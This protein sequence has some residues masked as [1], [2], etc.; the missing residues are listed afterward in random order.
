M[1]ATEWM[2]NMTAAQLVPFDESAPAW[3]Q[4]FYAFLAEKERRSGSKRTVD[5][6]SCTLQ[7]FFGA[8]GKT[9]DQVGPPDVFAFTHGVGPSGR[10]PAAITIGA[11]LA[12]VSSFYRFLMRMGIVTV[13]P[14][15][16]LE[17]PRVSPAPPRGL[18]AE[19]IKRL[20]CVIPETP[21]GLRDRAIIITLALTGRRRSEVMN[22]TASDITAAGGLFYTY[23]AKGGKQ[24]KR[25]LPGP[26]FEAIETSLASWGKTLAR[27]KFT[28]VPERDVYLCPQG[29][30]LAKRVTKHTEHTHLYQARAEVCNT[31]PVKSSCTESHKGRTILRPFDQAYIERVRRYHETAACRPAIN[32]RKVWVEPL[33][34]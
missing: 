33:F 10:R 23:R 3:E 11:R 16:Q 22:L 20:L 26:A 32:K 12:C 18:S 21:A 14:C 29:Q 24:A 6:Y 25:E 31:C 15:D 2:P 9:H 7:R 27:E 30:E 1:D 34:A 28:Y 8:L 5:A 13:N 17:R 19:E 4:A